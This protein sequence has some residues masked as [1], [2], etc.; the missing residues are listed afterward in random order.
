MW[1]L[2]TIPV[3]NREHNTSLRC[4]LY[5]AHDSFDL[6]SSGYDPYANGITHEPVLLVY[7]VDT[8]IDLFERSK[9]LRGGNKKLGSMCTSLC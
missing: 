3:S 9:L 8:A 6:R 2:L 7:Q 4:L 5:C 1:K